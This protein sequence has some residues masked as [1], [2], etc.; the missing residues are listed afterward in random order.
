MPNIDIKNNISFNKFKTDSEYR[1]IVLTIISAVFLLISWSGI[2]K[3]VI[4][5]D[6]ALVSVVISG[7]PI[8]LEAVKGLITSFDLKA[9]VL[10]SIALIASLL[11]GEYFAA[12]EIAVIMTIGEIL[13]D[14]TVRKARES[15]KKLLELTPP[16]ARIKTPDGER[17]IPV[18]DLAMGDILLV[19]PGESIPV[20]GI[21]IKGHTSIDQSILTGESMPVDKKIG[22]EVFIGTLNQLGVIE[23]E[24]TKVGEDTSLAKLIR[25]VRDSEDKKAPVVRLTDRV[26]TVIVPLAVAASLITYFLTQDIIRLVT[27]LVVFCPCALVLATPTAIMAGIG[28]ASRKGILIKSGE[29]LETVGKVD[30]IAFDKTG[31]ITY[32]KPEV[33]EVMSLSDEYTPEEILSISAMAEKFSEHPIGQAVLHKAENE[34]LSV[35]D[36]QKFRVELG[37]GVEADIDNQ[38]VLVGNRKLM[39]N[40]LVLI[41][42][43]MIDIMKFQENRGKTVLLVAIEQSIIGI[44]TVADR[45]KGESREIVEELKEIGIKEVFL[46]TGDNQVTAS[47]IARDIGV[48]RVYSQQLPEDKVRVIEEQLQQNRKVGMIGDGINDAPALARSNVGVAMGALGSDVAIET[49]DVALM[50]DDISKIPELIHLSRKVRGTINVNIVVPILINFTAIVLAAFGIIGPVAGALI[51]NLGSVLV[52]GNSSRLINYRR[53]KTSKKSKIIVKNA[54]SVSPP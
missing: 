28:N 14:R 15:V 17:E 48:D 41:T 31:T 44:I 53:N 13:E 49:A 51:H 19:K 18:E 47:S 32:G 27:I 35:D 33:A 38:Q 10:V 4:P 37:Q 3:N 20:D 46:L 23:V 52:V 40:N 30:V 6:V 42:P 24:A 22:D 9:N 11:I 26:A 5:F 45:I 7:T 21:I 12:A 36:P 1:S 39:D 43:E 50:S 2:L 25:L 29:A 34:L 54:E 8:L 16:M